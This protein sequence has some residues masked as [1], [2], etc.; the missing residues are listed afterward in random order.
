MYAARLIFTVF[1]LLLRVCSDGRSRCFGF[2]GFSTDK[3]AV[4]AKRTFNDTFIDTSKV[5]IEFAKPVRTISSL[6]SFP[7][8]PFSSVWIH[9]LWF[10]HVS[11]RSLSLDCGGI[12]VR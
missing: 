10:E 7:L 3:D 2:I 5:I 12:A 6:P 4:K 11:E 8:L 9:T 1:L